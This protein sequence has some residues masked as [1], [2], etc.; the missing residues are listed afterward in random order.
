CL[1]EVLWDDA[2]QPSD[3][4]YLEVNPAFEQQAGLQDAAGKTA[5]ELYGGLQEG[6]LHTVAGVARTGEP[7]R[8]QDYVAALD[9]WFDVY[10]FRFAEPSDHRI[11]AIFTDITERVRREAEREAFIAAMTHDLKSPLTTVQ[12]MAQLLARRAQQGELV[13]ADQLRASLAPIQAA[14]SRMVTM[15]N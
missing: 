4:R 7:V 2:G 8:H 12:G 10:F 5:R 13:T 9:R 15:L 11:A 1:L 6:W 3:L 14:T